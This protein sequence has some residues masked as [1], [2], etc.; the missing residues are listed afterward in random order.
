MSASRDIL[1]R[2]LD[3]LATQEMYH[4]R[5]RFR[6]F[7]YGSNMWTPR[8]QARCPSA[9]VIDTARL[10]GWQAVYDK[11][12]AD[13]SAKLNIRPHPDRSVAGVIYEID[14]GERHLLDRAEPR[15]RPIATPVG[16]TYAYDGKATL[17]LPFGWYVD[18]VEAGARAH[19]LEPPMPPDRVR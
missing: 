16:L 6:Y 12:S 18:L 17:E 2:H 14:L 11:P 10:L 5:M 3:I 19:G 13:G 8:M 4:S 1:A 15:Y 7:A 9:R